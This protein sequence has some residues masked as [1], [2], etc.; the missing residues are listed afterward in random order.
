[1]KLLE[2]HQVQDH[3]ETLTDKHSLCFILN[4]LAQ[5][6]FEKSDHVQTNWQDDAL[7]KQ[8]EKVA[9]SIETIADK[10]DNL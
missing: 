3:L 6:S 8:W 9:V 7:A 5:I 1:M 10:N 4:C 2:K